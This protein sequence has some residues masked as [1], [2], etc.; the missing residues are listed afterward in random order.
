MLQA[1][2]APRRSATFR[3]RICAKGAVVGFSLALA[4][5]LVGRGIRVVSVS[6][7]TVATPLTMNVQ[8]GN[9][10]F[11]YFERIRS[12]LGPASADQIAGTIAY[13]ASRDAGYL[14]G[15]DLR[16]DGGSHT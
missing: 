3:S 7:G 6:P 4:A 2:T 9:L 10:D 15:V 5:E 13:A 11:S 14:T 1:S 8:P 16:V 12:P